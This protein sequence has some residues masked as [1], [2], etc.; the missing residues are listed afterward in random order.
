MLM[1]AFTSEHATGSDR[2][3]VSL[4][5]SSQGFLTAIFSL[6]LQNLDESHFTPFRW[7]IRGKVILDFNIPLFHRTPREFECDV[8]TSVM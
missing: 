2:D 3:A 4:F 6:V 5:H 1:R 7:R 8:A